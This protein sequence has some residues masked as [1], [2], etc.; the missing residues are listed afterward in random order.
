M[1]ST[2]TLL[3]RLPRRELL[4]LTY[5]YLFPKCPGKDESNISQ[6][7][8]DHK[9]SI[10]RLYSKLCVHDLIWEQLYCLR[11]RVK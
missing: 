11:S 7:R 4:S 9:Y 3:G 10:G 2:H 5:L 8:V 1:K 6:N